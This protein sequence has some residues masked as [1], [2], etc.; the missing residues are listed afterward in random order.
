MHNRMIGR[1]TGIKIDYAALG[2]MLKNRREALGHTMYDA[3]EASGLSVSTFSRLEGNNDSWKKTGVDAET[4]AKCCLYMAVPMEQ[5]I[6]GLPRNE[7]DTVTA[8]G[9]ILQADRTIS[10]E[11][12]RALLE[13]VKATYERLNVL[14]KKKDVK[15]KG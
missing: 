8:I 3:A 1:T 15:D 4:Y 11:G 6:E 13:I 2:V 7:V 9:A 5:F 14:W 10:D 12:R